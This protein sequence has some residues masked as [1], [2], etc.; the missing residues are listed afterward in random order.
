MTYSDFVQSIKDHSVT[1]KQLVKLFI[2]NITSPDYSQATELLREC[3]REAFTM[4]EETLQ[5]I[6]F[7]LSVGFA[8]TR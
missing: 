4:L 5:N 2:D 3:R 1:N 6:F 7:I 8:D